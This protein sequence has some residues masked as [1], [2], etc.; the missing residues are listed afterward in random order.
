[1]EN[2]CRGAIHRAETHRTVPPPIIARSV[3]LHITRA[4]AIPSIQ[5][6][7]V[8]GKQDESA[9]QPTAPQRPIYE[10][11]KIVKVGKVPLPIIEA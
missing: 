1:M 6:M 7:L 9:V 11:G 4:N 10:I 5:A 2:G 3:R 8:Y